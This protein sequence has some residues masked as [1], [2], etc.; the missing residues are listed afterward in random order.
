MKLDKFSLALETEKL[1]SKTEL[2][3]TI[4][5]TTFASFKLEE[6]GKDELHLTIIF[7]DDSG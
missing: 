5:D 1:L 3:H 6:G 4:Q 7:N 2:E